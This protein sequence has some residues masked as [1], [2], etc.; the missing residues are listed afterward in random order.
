[1]YIEGY[2]G[3]EGGSRPLAIS[4]SVADLL[5]LVLLVI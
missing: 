5:H 4:D 1:M 3:G 2:G